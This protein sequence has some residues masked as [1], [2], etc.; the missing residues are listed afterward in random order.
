MRYIVV[1]ADERSE[2]DRLGFG[3]N[4]WHLVDTETDTVIWSDGMEPED[5]I[6][7]RDLSDLVDMLNEQAAEI[8]RL[9]QKNAALIQIVS[10]GLY[11]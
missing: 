7:V 1:H 2:L 11:R 3:D 8:D 9:K 5:A 4:C 6:L 10:D